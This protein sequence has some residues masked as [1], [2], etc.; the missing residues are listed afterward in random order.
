MALTMNDQMVDALKQKIKN[1][2]QNHRR[3]GSS[4]SIEGPLSIDYSII[5]LPK[6]CNAVQLYFANETMV[7]FRRIVEYYGKVTN[8]KRGMPIGEMASLIEDYVKG[9]SSYKSITMANLDNVDWII[10]TRHNKLLGQHHY[11]DSLMDRFKQ[12]NDN[13]QLVDWR[14]LKLYH[15]TDEF[16]YRRAYAYFFKR[17]RIDDGALNA[18]IAGD[19]LLLDRMIEMLNVLY[20]GYDKTGKGDRFEYYRLLQK[21]LMDIIQNFADLVE[22]DINLCEKFIQVTEIPINFKVIPAK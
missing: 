15:Y 9:W 11:L 3:Y 6:E 10:E 22:C 1:M 12:L 4:S 8:D 19:T 7:A 21:R 18:R 2:A 14:N 13:S 5:K 20:G 17:E 16:P